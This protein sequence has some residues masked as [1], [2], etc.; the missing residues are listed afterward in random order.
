[1]IYL[2]NKQDRWCPENNNGDYI[3]AIFANEQNAKEYSQYWNNTDIAYDYFI[4][5]KEFFDDTFRHE[6]EEDKQFRL[7]NEGNE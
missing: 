7:D 5:S 1:M 2:I 3:V 6:I 4:D